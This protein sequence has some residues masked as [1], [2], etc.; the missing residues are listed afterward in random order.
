M[1]RPLL[2]LL[3][4]ATPAAA[5][6]LRI[7]MKAA[8]DS[9][10]PHLTYTP[11]RNVG[12][13]V[14][15]TLTDLNPTLRP[16]PGL[17]ESWRAIDEL[18]WEFTLR[19]GVR[20][21]DGTPFTSEDAAFSIRRAQTVTGA[22][23]YASAVRNVASVETPDPRRLILRMRVPTPMQPHHIASIGMVSARAATDAAEADFNGG[24]AAIGT[25]PYRWVRWTPGTEV[26]LERAGTWRGTPEP[27]ARVTFR[28]MA[29]DSS[30]VAALLAGDVDVIDTVPA[31]LHARV[32][33][34]DRTKLV[35]TES[36]FTHYLYMDSMSARVANATGADGQPL[37]QNPLRDQRVR[38][39][40]SHA[41]NRVALAERAM[42]GG[43]TPA[44]QVAAPGLIGHD[45]AAPAIAYDPALARRLLA[46]AGYPQGFGLNLQCTSDRFA[47]DARTCQAIGQMLTAIGIKAS[48]EALPIAVYFR[49][50]TQSAPGGEPE[51]SAHLSM[52]GSTLGIA[53]ESLTSLIRTID[54]KL[55]HGGWNR[56]R[57]SNPELDR[58]LTEAEGIF[59]DAA[60]EKGIQAAARYAVDQQA[61][62]PIFFV[63][64][65]WGIRRGLTMVP[66]ADSFTMATTTRAAP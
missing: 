47:G 64:A 41:I 21:H 23:T 28:A 39:A 17:A 14:F 34:S 6:E 55:G 63:R 33:E 8:V 22:R 53:S 9:A 42:E 36:I 12:L 3:M 15:E 56:T 51:L 30:R 65:S 24:R 31:G 19:E 52:F 60:R 1:L 10:D 5:Q 13:H 25:G 18:T 27:W 35:S 57:Y 2:A 54:P 59:D 32:R 4:L 11:N 58:L 50:G 29:N 20:F 26:V 37:P 44:Y 45:P 62:L 40:M 43:A 61:L 48:I 16:V 38:K 49:R 46:E 7:G 66:R